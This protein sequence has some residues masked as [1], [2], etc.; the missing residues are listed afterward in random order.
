ML[1]GNWSWLTSTRRQ[2]RSMLRMSWLLHRGVPSNP[3]ITR[4]V[5][6]A[7]HHID[8]SYRAVNSSL[9]YVLSASWKVHDCTTA[10][11]N[12]HQFRQG[13][14]S[15][16]STPLDLFRNTAMGAS[17]EQLDPTDEIGR[18]TCRESVGAVGVDPGGARLVKKK[19]KQTL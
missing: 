13:Y 14:Q 10:C 6:K 1:G 15:T 16:N 7:T 12:G 19:I 2:S 5:R 18:A 4:T 8:I 11:E 3:I 17:L 9:P